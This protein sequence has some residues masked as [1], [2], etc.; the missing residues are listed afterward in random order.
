MLT[1]MAQRVKM[2]APAKWRPACQQSTTE[3]NMAR[4][5]TEELRALLDES[6]DRLM[7]AGMTEDEAKQ[8]IRALIEHWEAESVFAEDAA[9]Q[10][11]ATG[12]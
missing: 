6:R 3:V 9:L 10:A 7:R 11:A 2:S 4:D 5:L 12:A 1:I 8:R